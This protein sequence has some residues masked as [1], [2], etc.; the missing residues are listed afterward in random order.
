MLTDPTNSS[1]FHSSSLEEGLSLKRGRLPWQ[2][3][4]QPLLVS[5]IALTVGVILAIGLLI[6]GRRLSG[7]LSTELPPNT[8]LLLALVSASALAYT[9]I[10]WRRNFPLE[11]PEEL[12]FADRLVGWGSSSALVLLAVGC[13]YPGY[14]TV[15]WLIWLP[16]LVADQM[17]CQNFFDAGELE[18]TEIF[19]DELP[20]TLALADARRH[21]GPPQNHSQKELVQQLFR[22]RDAQGQEVI[23]GTVRADFV[24]EQRTAVVHVGFCPPLEY[25]PEIEAEALSCEGAC[26]GAGE[27]TAKIKVVQSLAHGARLDVRL[28]RFPKADCQVWI[29]LA[30]TPVGAVAETTPHVKS[31]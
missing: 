16:I 12:S 30:A 25:L 14:R 1:V 13:C 9:R 19:L 3:R 11:T 20:R 21:D 26:E 2:F 8:M 24:A 7:A 28:S 5:T 22:L 10:A 18:S 29:D 4:A 27:A 23:Y 17:W 15:D 6:V 31:A